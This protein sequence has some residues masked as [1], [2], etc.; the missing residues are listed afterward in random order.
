M[1][2]T[3]SLRV[4]MDRLHASAPK[5]RCGGRRPIG[6]KGN[7]SARAEEQE[8]ACRNVKSPCCLPSAIVAKAT[9]DDEV[10]TC[11]ARRRVVRHQAPHGKWF[12]KCDHAKPLGTKQAAHPA[13]SFCILQCDQDS[14]RRLD[15][16]CLAA[17]VVERVRFGISAWDRDGRER[18]GC[19][20]S[21]P[22][23]GPSIGQLHAHCGGTWV[24]SRKRSLAW[25]PSALVL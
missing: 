11:Q 7:E 23:G 3:W 14:R 1:H 16:A 8:K 6:G 22:F 13:P 4:V 20:G 10:E 18:R 25:L 9:T 17:I 19:H 2:C 5:C 12:V 15:V 21:G 24:T